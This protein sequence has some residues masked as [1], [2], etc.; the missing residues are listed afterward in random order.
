M[1]QAHAQQKVE[2]QVYRVEDGNIR[3]KDG[4]SGDTLFPAKSQWCNIRLQPPEPR[5]YTS[6]TKPPV[7]RVHSVYMYIWAD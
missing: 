5:Q 2:R 6:L 4:G 1:I 3:T 7:Y